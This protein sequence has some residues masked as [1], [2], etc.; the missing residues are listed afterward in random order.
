[1]WIAFNIF[2]FFL[3]SFSP[4]VVVFLYFSYALLVRTGYKCEYSCVC[5]TPRCS[6]MGGCDLRRAAF[7]E[8]AQP[9]HR[10]T[11]IVCVYYY[12][13]IW[14]YYLYGFC[15]YF[16]FVCFLVLLLPV[17]NFFVVAGFLSHLALRSVCENNIYFFSV[18]GS[19]GSIFA[20]DGNNIFFLLC[21]AW[22]HSPTEMQ[23]CVPWNSKNVRNTAEIQN[24]KSHVSKVPHSEN[25]FYGKYRRSIL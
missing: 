14:M 6:C 7:V 22:R 15:F 25:S 18:L 10:N 12:V 3:L 24:R 13:M 1:M 21:W 9:D 23:K 16:I 2:F 11:H 8:M 17:S 4:A 20:I 5:Y 19:F